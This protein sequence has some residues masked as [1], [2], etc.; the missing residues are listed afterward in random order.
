MHGTRFLLP[1]NKR[2]TELWICYVTYFD[3]C[4]LLKYACSVICQ[5][6]PPSNSP[7]LEKFKVF[8]CAHL[9]KAVSLAVEAALDHHDGGGGPGGLQALLA[10]GVGGEQLEGGAP[11]LGLCDHLLED[12]L[13]THV[14]PDVHWLLVHLDPGHRGHDVQETALTFKVFAKIIYFLYT[15]NFLYPF[16]L[17]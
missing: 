15:R 16:S 5:F 1:A 14:P 4:Y 17:P 12:I 13:A 6:L 3:N 2:K 7:S 9:Y 10:P 8:Y 11:S